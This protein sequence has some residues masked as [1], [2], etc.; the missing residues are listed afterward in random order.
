MFKN[1]KI[2]DVEN[3]QNCTPCHGHW[4]CTILWIFIKIEQ[5]INIV[6]TW[7]HDIL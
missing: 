1:N 7:E 5:I 6:I 2:V 4:L 3:K